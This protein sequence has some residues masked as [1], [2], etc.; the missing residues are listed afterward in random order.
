VIVR[1]VCDFCGGSDVRPM[2]TYGPRCLVGDF[3]IAT[4]RVENVWCVRC[5]LGWNRLMMSAEELT[6]FYAAYEKKTAS[7][8]ED[9]LLFASD[10]EVETL[11]ASQARFLAANVTAA[12]G[13]ALDIGCGKGSFLRALHAL[14]PGWS[15]VGVEPSREE[16]AI[17]RREPAFEIHE[18]MFG[19]VALGPGMRDRFDLIAIMHVLEHVPVP[20]ATIAAMHQA[21]KPGGLL[22]VEVPNTLD[23]NMFYDLLLY[24]HLFHFAPDTLAWYLS[25]HGFDLVATERSTSYG[26][27]RILVRKRAGGAAGARPLPDAGM[28]AGFE[29]WTD[30]WDRM[31][32]L[33]GLGAARARAGANVALFGAGMTAA[34]WLV[35]TALHHAPLVGCFDESPWKIG[36]TFF[37]RPVRAL[38]DIDVVRPDVMLIATMPG[39]QRFVAEKLA[40]WGARGVEILGF[41]SLESLAR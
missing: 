19:D 20:S 16:A 22:F 26:A 27:Q 36:R 34:T 12:A 25:G 38:Q 35:Y 21:L 18:G 29:A 17:A 24:E 3:K 40:P 32:A 10:A 2:N 31:S 37:G 30:L 15:L 14:R 28:A 1:T 7:E 11:T 8:D 33:A 6:R 4:G 41:G 39:S 13:V 23:P 5:G 9:D